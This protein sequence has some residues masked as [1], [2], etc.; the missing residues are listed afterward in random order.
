MNANDDVPDDDIDDI[1]D[2]EPTAEEI[3]TM[4]RATA[5]QAEGVDALILSK[6]TAM[7]SK[8]AAVV[9]ASLDEYEARFPGLPY[10]YLQVR[11]LELEEAGRIE[12]QGDVMAMRASELRL[13][14][15]GGQGS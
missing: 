10:V 4:R 6:C 15:S 5:A 7:W 13:R 1:D 14:S 12:I 3:A 11:M 8:V 2:G 9:G